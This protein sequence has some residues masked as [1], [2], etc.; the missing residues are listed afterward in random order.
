[1]K[2]TTRIMT[3][4]MITV[5]KTKITAVILILTNDAHGL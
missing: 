3:L 2:T 4:K 1:L 5:M